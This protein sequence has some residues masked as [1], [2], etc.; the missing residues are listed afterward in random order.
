MLVTHK[1]RKIYNMQTQLVYNSSTAI[2]IIFLV[3]MI[4]LELR[5]LFMIK[6][7]TRLFLKLFVLLV[8]VLLAVHLI[9]DHVTNVN[10]VHDLKGLVINNHVSGIY[11]FSTIQPSIDI[12]ISNI[13]T[14][15]LSS[16]VR[17]TS[18]VLALD[19]YEQLTCA[20]RSLIVDTFQSDTEF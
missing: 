2:L 1:I 17:V 8:T 4:K 10:I 15:E 14:A 13:N 19:Y 3:I 16:H 5:N 11:E 9:Y 18:F 12:S 6:K 7:C 20:T